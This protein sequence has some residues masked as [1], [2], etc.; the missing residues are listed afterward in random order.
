MLDILYNVF[1]KKPQDDGKVT[2]H[3]AGRLLHHDNKIFVLEDY[4]G[5]LNLLLHSDG[6]HHPSSLKALKR[7][8]YVRVVSQKDTEIEPDLHEPHSVFEYH[9]D[10]MQ[11]PHIVEF[12]NGV[13]HIQNTRLSQKEIDN[14]KNNVKNGTAKIN[15]RINKLESAIK[16]MES[17]FKEFKKS[18]EAPSSEDIGEAFQFIRNLIS[19]HP[20]AAKHERTLAHFIYKDGVVPEVGSRFAFNDFKTRPRGGVHVMMDGNDF[21]SIN[22]TLGHPAGDA[23]IKTFGKVLRESINEVAPNQGKLFRVGGDEFAAHLPTM[24][25]AA[26]FA[27][28]LREKLDAIPAFGGTHKLSLSLGFGDNPEMADK[29]LLEA[30]KQKFQSDDL[31]E[32]RFSV[33]QVPNLAHSLVSGSE[34]PVPVD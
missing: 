21:K 28:K 18:E 29:A 19:S 33:G 15:Y 9:A 1:I 23:A 17:I 11:K 12:I 31:K 16:K 4:H 6:M 10:G 14:I 25:H 30:K 7:N 5:L 22:D 26:H 24:H 8:P 27:R 13:P 34:G 32:R 2:E 20:E 3:L